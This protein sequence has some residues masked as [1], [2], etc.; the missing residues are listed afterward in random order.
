MSSQNSSKL[1]IYAALVGNLLVA[2]TKFVAAALSG[3]SSMLSEGVH[4]LVDT[5]NEVL[6]LYGI[7][8]AGRAP[9]RAH[10]LGYGRE[11]YFWSFIVAL[12]L[13]ALGAGVSIY[14]GV[15][16]MMTP[17]PIENAHLNYI[18]LALS[19]VFEGVSWYV[20]LRSFRRAKGDLGTWE[21]VR[22]SKDPPSFMVL[23]E[24]SAALIGIAIAALGTFCADV[25]KM[26]AL[27]GAASIL[28]GAVLAL[29]SV[30]LA[31]ESKGLLIGE[32]ADSRIAGSIESLA[33]GESGVSGA[34][35]VITVHLAPD[36][37]V[38]ALSLEFDDALCT[39][40]IEAAVSQLEKRVH[41]RH[42]EVVALF[43]KP[44]T[45][46]AFELRERARFGGDAPAEPA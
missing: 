14:E 26:P 34:N 28:I 8:R 32:R 38:V 25:L 12:M 40:Q 41:E 22:K 21:A 36:Q 1:V 17:E 45:R 30:L 18:V 44:Q 29:T 31:R 4:S 42:P 10:P 7:R 35:G 46:G 2:L 11:L 19:F 39:P 43:V 27:D 15:Q 20:A 9:D 13:F 6:L 5:F 16:H 23:F 37:I 24:D 3:S 33:A